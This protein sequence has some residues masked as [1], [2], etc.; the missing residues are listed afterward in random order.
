MTFVQMMMSTHV[1]TVVNLQTTV[2][3]MVSVRSVVLMMSDNPR[4]IG[5][6]SVTIQ[7]DDLETLTNIMDHDM[8]KSG[9]IA[10][11]IELLEVDLDLDVGV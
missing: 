11:I 6:V 8:D 4:V 9:I 10:H 3:M 1:N 2:M 5:T 7:D